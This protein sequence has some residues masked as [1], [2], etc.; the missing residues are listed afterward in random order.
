MTI[1]IAPDAFKGSLS[2]VQA[3][4]IMKKAVLDVDS[5]VSVRSFPMA[6]GGEGTLDALIASGKGERI[7]IDCTG[8]LGK[9]IHTTYG[10]T[11]E[12]TAI[13][14]CAN[15][16]GLPQVSPEKRNPDRT[17]SYGIG[18]VIIDALNKGCKSI[19]IGLGGSAT[20]DGGLGMLQ[21]IGLRAWDKTGSLVGSF[22]RDLLHV[23]KVDVSGLDPRLRSV[24][25]KAAS[26]VDNLLCGKRGASAVYGPQKGATQEQVVTYDHA[27]GNYASL[28]ESMLD[29]SLQHKDGAGAAGGLGFALLAIGGDLLSGAELV[30]DTLHL[31]EEI[32]Q[33]DLIITGEGQSDE[34]TLYGK[35]PGYVAGLGVANDVPAV[36]ISG[37]VTGNIDS[38][39]EVFSGCFSIVNQPLTLEECLDHAETLLKNQT[40]QMMYFWRALQRQN[41]TL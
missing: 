35:A 22:G 3:M 40:K 37:S 10:I 5:E 8:P 16:A 4:E 7:A 29:Q 41:G 27:L 18:E 32:K 36:L 38:L 14:E 20:N 6:D 31:E 26:D 33:A 30:A 19:V 9:T 21:A 34:Q 39:N 11:D 24:S 23:A 25:I 28:I 2:A 17:T 12:K 1:V 15:I 13:I